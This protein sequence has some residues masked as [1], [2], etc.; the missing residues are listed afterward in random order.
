MVTETYIRELCGRSD[1]RTFDPYDIWMTGVG[2]HVKNF[3]NHHRYLGLVGA[4]SLTLFDMMLGEMR[5]R[6][7]V[8]REYP[9]VRSWAVLILLNYFKL[10]NS[11]NNSPCHRL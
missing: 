3:Y 7:Y 8:P 11:L 9:I 10:F 4:G 2:F 1:L 6:V 5:P